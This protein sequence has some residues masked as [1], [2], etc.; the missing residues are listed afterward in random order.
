[1]SLEQLRIPGLGFAAIVVL[2]SG[3][4]LARG[5]WPYGTGWVT[6]HKLVALAA[7][8]AVACLVY[9]ANRA[10]PF[11]T[12]ELVVVLF[13]AAS[14]VAAFASGGVVAASDNAPAWAF[15]IHR[16]VPYVAVALSGAS[17]YFA[18]VRG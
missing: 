18:L 11:S 13:A 1:M 9:Q 8:V 7:T 14:V 16:I 5:A 4:W 10:T 6:I 17:T 2:A 3:L 15:P 12:L